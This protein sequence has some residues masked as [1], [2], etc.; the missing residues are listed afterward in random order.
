MQSRARLSSH[1]WIRPH[2]NSVFAQDSRNLFLL[3]EHGAREQWKY[4]EF[5]IATLRAAVIKAGIAGK[6]K[7]ATQTNTHGILTTYMKKNALRANPHWR[8]SS[9]WRIYERWFYCTTCSIVQL[10]EQYN[11][12]FVGIELSSYFIDTGHAWR[13][14][15]PVLSMVLLLGFFFCIFL[16][17]S[18]V[19]FCFR[20]VSQV[21]G[22]ES[23]DYFPNSPEW[24]SNGREVIICWWWNDW[25]WS[26]RMHCV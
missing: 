10:E 13:C 11:E 26:H 19:I 9:S 22:E 21:K 5:D 2:T 14:L 17:I 16:I 24:K 3:S 25:V 8:R 1:T 18:K 6:A 4:F 23:N 7:N 12:K 20:W 15:T